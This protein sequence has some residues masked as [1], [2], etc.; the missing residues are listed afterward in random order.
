M[1]LEDVSYTLRHR[2]SGRAPGFLSSVL[3]AQFPKGGS[4]EVEEPGYRVSGGE[5][6]KNWSFLSAVYG[7]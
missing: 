5:T 3:A 6:R 4:Y 1:S 7:P 2:Y